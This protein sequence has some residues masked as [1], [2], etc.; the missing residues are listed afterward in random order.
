MVIALDELD[1]VEVGTGESAKP[2]IVGAKG[3]LYFDLE[4]IPDYDRMD[5]FDLEPIPEPSKRGDI[6]KCPP[7][8]DILKQ[9]VEK[10]KEDL[11]FYNPE[12]S[13]LD[14]IDAAEKIIAKPRKGVF[15]TTESLRRQDQARSDA[16]A[17]RR[18]LMSLTPEFCRI[19]ALGYGSLHNTESLVVGDRITEGLM[20][21]ERRILEDFWSL[22]MRHKQ[23]CGFNILNFDLPVIFMRSI[24]LDVKPTRIFDMKP[25]GNDVID[26]MKKRFPKSGAMGLK[27]IAT[28]MGIEIPAGDVDGSMV[29]ELFESDPQKL[30][31][32]VRSD[33]DLVKVIHQMYTGFFC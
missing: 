9:T 23:V 21:D 20:F 10:I 2:P 28:A 14:L 13:Y 8:C 15:E 17:A 19:V 1:A 22:A 7:V 16:L 25:W 12:D 4:T 26:L 29:Q 27:K 24:I 11:K 30:G 5:C 32:Y 33:V 3:V 31:V 6:D 18:K